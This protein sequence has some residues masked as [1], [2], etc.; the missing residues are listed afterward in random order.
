VA[1]ELLLLEREITAPLLGVGPVSFTT[2]VEEAPPLTLVGLRVIEDKVAE[3]GG[4]V[5]PV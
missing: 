4:V 2:P 1:T 5:V 3:G